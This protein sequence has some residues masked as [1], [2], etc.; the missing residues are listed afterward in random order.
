MLRSF[1]SRW[2]AAKP[3]KHQP[4]RNAHYL[5]LHIAEATRKAGYGR[6]R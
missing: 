4:M 3:Q 6:W 5:G 1:W 2:I